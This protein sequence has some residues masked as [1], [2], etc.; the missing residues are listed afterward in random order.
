MHA[1]RGSRRMPL[2]ERKAE[3][4]VVLECPHDGKP[5]EKRAVEGVVLDRCTTCG[6]TWFD[7]RELGRVTDDKELE[8]LA[9]RLPL[10]KVVSPFRCPRCGHECVEGHVA[11]VEIDTCTECHGVWLDK[12]ELVEAQRRLR[13][14]RLIGGAGLGFRAFLTRL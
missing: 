8:Q 5:M 7:A 9:T 11:E 14:E 10:V 3:T 13:S 1:Q 6:G 2:F 12:G 4:E